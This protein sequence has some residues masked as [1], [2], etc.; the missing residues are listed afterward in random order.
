MRLCVHGPGAPQDSGTLLRLLLVA[1]VLTR[2]AEQ[3]GAQVI[4]AATL[5]DP[6]AHRVAQLKTSAAALGIHPPDAFVTPADAST[7]LDGSADLY[8]AATAPSGDG[9]HDAPWIQ[10]GAAQPARALVAPHEPEPLAVRLTVLCSRYRDPVTLTGHT[11]EQS[12]A[13]IERWRDLVAAWATEPSRPVHR[14]TVQRCED[15]LDDDLGTTQVL[16]ALRDLEVDAHVPAGAKFETFAH[17]DR[18]LGLDL[19]R[20][21]GRPGR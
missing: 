7:Y 12:R 9:V 14:D 8:I 18:V 16:A 13:L 1:D 17:L 6:S 3:R 21:V 15:A 4:L 10:V 5:P 19:A 11:L 20:D 2:I